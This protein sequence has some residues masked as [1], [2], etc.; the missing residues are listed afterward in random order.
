MTPATKTLTALL[1]SLGLL[2]TASPAW[3]APVVVT[4]SNGDAWNIYAFGNGGVLISI[5]ESIAS[6]VNSPDYHGLLLF[7]T[8]LSFL[9]MAVVASITGTMRGAGHK[10]L[11]MFIGLIFLIDVGFGTVIDANVID[12]LGIPPSGATTVA[13]ANIPFIVGVPES[14][15]TTAGHE[16]TRLFETNFSLPNL[17]GMGS[18]GVSDGGFDLANN[19]LS[20]ETRLQIDNANFEQTLA[21]F[22]QNCIMPS[23]ASGRL[24]A[25]TLA[26]SPQLFSTTVNAG[27]MSNVN[28]ALV[29]WVYNHDYPQGDAVY[30][31]PVSGNTATTPGTGTSFMSSPGN[32]YQYISTFLKNTNLSQMNP[33]SMGV[34]SFSGT[35]ADNWMGAVQASTQALLMSNSNNTAAQN[36]EQAAVI[37]TLNPALREAAAMSG[38]SAGMMAISIAQGEQEQVSGWA[39]AATIFRQ[40]SGYLYAVLQALT[41]AITPLV[42]IALFI[43]GT[44]FKLVGSYFQVAVW[45]AIWQPLLAVV[46]FIVDVFSAEESTNMLQG[47]TGFTMQN[48]PVI[49]QF[50]SHMILAASFV[51]SMVPLFAWGLVRGGM[52]MTDMI[53]G[54]LGRS[55][56]AQVG[57]T[58]ATGNV[59]LGNES[60]DNTTADQNMLMPKYSVGYGMVNAGVDG[61]GI[62][63]TFAQGGNAETVAG[64]AVNSSVSSAQSASLKRLIDERTALSS[65]DTNLA[66]ESASNIRAMQHA[67]GSGGVATDGGNSS[68]GTGTAGNSGQA[69]SIGAAGGVKFNASEVGTH[70]TGNSQRTQQGVETGIGVPKAGAG[71]KPG[72]GGAGGAPSMLGL[73]NG[74]VD[75]GASD[76]TDIGST[77]ATVGTTLQDASVAADYKTSAGVSRVASS[78]NNAVSTL[79]GMKSQMST[80]TQGQQQAYAKTLASLQAL[81]KSLTSTMAVDSAITQNQGVS[82]PVGLTVGAMAGL[83]AERAAAM[84]HE[85]SLINAGEAVG[86]TAPAVHPATAEALSSAASSDLTGG[87]VLN[88][89]VADAAERGGVVRPAV[90]GQ[91]A[92]VDAAT[93][94]PPNGDYPTYQDGTAVNSLFGGQETARIGDISSEKARE[95]A[96]EEA[97]HK[98]GANQATAN[99]GSAGTSVTTPKGPVYDALNWL[100]QL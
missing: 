37:N 66:A 38:T 95:E 24:N 70:A 52:A 54:G 29:T 43:P 87:P 80:W 10:L 48:M 49:T 64:S 81:Q 75:Y 85:A 12:N 62:V 34:V 84:R 89:G 88:P 60:L 76:G 1:T 5:L 73:L 32:A 36:I 90:D 28:P 26:M 31:G 74:G 2:L 23:L 56:M 13:V 51:G 14:I 50:A 55:I 97:L 22:S 68:A 57:N 82:T 47:A 58:A 18:L 59:T 77:L 100:N 30:C 53:T 33:G 4:Q 72:S 6:L 91:T 92:G 44:G 71:G 17:G 99:L 15:I 93:A 67:F 61:N 65:A 41:L 78:V 20:A 19:M 79:V 45:L 21:A 69:A 86:R 42:I 96:V 63:N 27:A 35:P 7:V 83:A 9:A 40:M 16:L 3:A 11:G 94:G 46:N 25:T 98:D 39:T 8:I